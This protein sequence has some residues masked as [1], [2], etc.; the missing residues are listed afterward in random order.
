[1]DTWSE[2]FMEDTLDELRR[3]EE[4]WRPAATTA[5]V[6]Q[7]GHGD[8]DPALFSNGCKVNIGEQ[9]DRGER[10]VGRF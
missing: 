2:C 4:M 1:M 10:H 6:L 5:N 8:V 7:R 3:L 9:L